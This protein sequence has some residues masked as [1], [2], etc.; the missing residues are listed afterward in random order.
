VLAHPGLGDACLEVA[1]RARMHYAEANK[2][3]SRQPRRLV[4]APRMM[5]A[6]Y[7]SVLERTM[8]R[9]FAAPRKR[10]STGKLR[11]IGALIRYGFA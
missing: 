10:V 5:E 4:R 3:M 6:A 8:K 1:E 11:V 9:G 7:G 2:V